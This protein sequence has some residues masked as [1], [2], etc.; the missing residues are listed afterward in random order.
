LGGALWHGYDQLQQPISD[1]TAQG[2]PN[3]VLLLG[4]T[5][6]YE[7]FSIIFVVSAVIYFR[8][9][10]SR[11]L[12]T[13]LIIFLFMHIVSVLYMFFPESPAGGTVD[14]QGVMHIAVTALIVPLTILFPF[15]IYAGMRKLR[16]FEGYA[17]YSLVT[18]VII[19]L[20]G[21][22]SAIMAAKQLPYF[23][24]AER[25]NIGALQLWMF[26]VSLK[27]FTYSGKL[28]IIRSYYGR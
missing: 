13:G 21:G 9:L 8:G 14:F 5:G 25:I 6:A 12:K 4:F 22:A 2:A 10:R 3:R 1:L 20:A 17:V 16:N 15:F 26:I 18:G 23:G 27:L 11:S 19:F 24:L 7:L 28:K